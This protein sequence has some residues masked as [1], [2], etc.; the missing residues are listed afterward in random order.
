MCRRFQPG[1]RHSWSWHSGGTSLQ[2]TQVLQSS[3]PPSAAEAA[4]IGILDDVHR[5]WREFPSARISCRSMLV[6]V[7]MVERLSPNN[8]TTDC[9]STSFCCFSNSPKYFSDAPFAGYRAHRLPSTAHSLCS[10]SVLPAS[11]SGCDS[12]ALVANSRAAMWHS[13]K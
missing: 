11:R 8:C 13:G 6:S 1:A 10:S 12:A 3:V 5:P 4:L 7:S 9:G 2:S